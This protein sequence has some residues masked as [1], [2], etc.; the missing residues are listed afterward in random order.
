MSA[1]A[2]LTVLAE[3]SWDPAVGPVPQVAGFVHSSFHPLVAE[4]AERCLR[5]RHGEPPAPADRAERTAL[6]VV[7]ARGDLAS[8]RH[9]ASTVDEGRR[10]GPLFFFQSVPNSIAGYVAARWGLGGPVVCLSPTGDPLADGLA[11]AGLLIADGEADEALVVVVEQAG[12]DG[13]QDRA[14]AVLVG[15]GVMQ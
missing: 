1:R 12:V 13:E 8:A 6:I 4:L 11:E 14:S 5:K 10:P 15:E 2:Q 9:V 3:A 7:S